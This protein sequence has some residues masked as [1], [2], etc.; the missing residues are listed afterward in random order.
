M[1]Y[2]LG[3]N[4]SGQLGIGHLEDVSRPTLV[5][6]LVEEP[7]AVAGLRRGAEQIVAGGNHTLVLN[8]YGV[9]SGTGENEDGR[10]GLS[11]REGS[12]RL[13]T[14]KR[15]QSEKSDEPFNVDQVAATWSASVFVAMGGEKVSVC[16]TGE[17]GELGLG[18]GVK[19]ASERMVLA[20]FPPPETR[21]VH[22]AACMAH[23]VAVLSNGE[24]WGWGKGR[25]GQLGE[26]CVDIW[27]PRK[28]EAVPFRA[29][30]AVCGKDFTCV[31]GP[32]STGEILVLGPNGNDRF[33]V[34]MNAPSKV[35]GWMSVVAS[36]GSVF[37]MMADS[38]IVAWGR[39]DHGQ[40]PPPHLPTLAKLAAGSEHCVAL[41]TDG[42]V[43]AWGWG[44]HG[45]C[46]KAVDKRGDV[47]G[48]YNELSVPGTVADVFAGCATSFVSIVGEPD[49][50]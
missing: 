2:A 1:L 4:G 44:E 15:D 3:S 10:C 38:R 22:I 5:G 48:T 46:G 24:V 19:R 12:T 26:A 20:D 13:R 23:V 36:W 25:K 7:A 43:L 14:I 39:D 34:R 16:G 28:I 41:S 33:G 17:S 29:A 40:L 30:T 8:R 49:S 50:H 11:S 18:E 45:N 42:K 6:E 32:P 37:I 31:L 9:A 35:P 47:K 21:I 27:R